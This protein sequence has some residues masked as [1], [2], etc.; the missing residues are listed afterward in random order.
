MRVM[1]RQMVVK[2]LR[3]IVDL[4]YKVSSCQT[5]VLKTKL[6]LTLLMLVTLFTFDACVIFLFTLALA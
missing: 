4:Y 2:F 5:M 1:H 6:V 3:C